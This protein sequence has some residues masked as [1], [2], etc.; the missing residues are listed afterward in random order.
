MM[1]ECK[2]HRDPYDGEFDCGYSPEFDCGDCI[3]NGGTMSPQTG[4]RFR[5]NPKPY[6]EVVERDIYERYVKPNLK[7]RGMYLYGPQ[8]KEEIF[9]NGLSV[10][11]D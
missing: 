6:I 8:K 4:K 11:P 3:I 1:I 2:G 7:Y 5:G 10:S 9:F